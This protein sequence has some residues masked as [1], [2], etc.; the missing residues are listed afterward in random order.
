MGTAVPPQPL[1]L[2]QHRIGGFRHV[3]AGAEDFG[4]I[5]G[6]QPTSSYA[7]FLGFTERV[8]G[9]TTALR[10]S[11]LKAEDGALWRALRLIADICVQAALRLPSSA[12]RL[13][14]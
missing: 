6:A 2:G 8:L 3:G 14:S 12:F 4:D 11:W 1:H 10:L 13:A 9:A 7:K 5:G